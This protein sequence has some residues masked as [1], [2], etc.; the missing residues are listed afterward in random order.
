[1]SQPDFAQG[2]LFWSLGGLFLV[3]CESPV[4]CSILNFRKFRMVLHTLY[5]AEDDLIG[6]STVLQQW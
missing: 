1:M 4:A 6:V 5:P 3:P 2:V